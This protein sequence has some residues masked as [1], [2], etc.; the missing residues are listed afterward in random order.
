MG[1]RR[2][3]ALEANAVTVDFPKRAGQK[4]TL[5]AAKSALTPLA[6]GDPRVLA[7]W[8]PSELERLRKEDPIFLVVGVLKALR[9]EVTATE[10][11]KLLIAWGAVPSSGW[12]P[13]WNATKKRLADDPRI[14]ASHAFE[15]RYA[16]G[17]EG[18]AVRLPGFPRHEPPRKAFAADSPPARAA[19]GREAR[20]ERTWTEGLLRWARPGSAGRRRARRR[21]VV[22]GRAARPIRARSTR[23]ASCCWPTRSRAT[24]T[25]RA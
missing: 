16:I 10:I 6:D 23:A 1:R 4:M 12:T 18:Q 8:E 13:F 9:R 5:A 19:P 3:T 15:Q 7:A 21:A 2:V 24:S 11:K 17:R 20:L 25:S 14:D 22:G